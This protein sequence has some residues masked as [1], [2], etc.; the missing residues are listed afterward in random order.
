DLV[1]IYSSKVYVIS[2]G[3]IIKSGTPKEVFGDID[4]IRSANLR[5]PRVAHLFE[6]LDKRD[7]FDLDGDYPLTISEARRLA[8]ELH[9]H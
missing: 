3:E 6:I 1:P 7:N 8:V 2:S 5:L 4:L 9:N